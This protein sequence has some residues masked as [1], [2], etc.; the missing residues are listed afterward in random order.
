MLFSNFMSGYQASGL[1]FW[2]FF[3]SSSAPLLPVLSQRVYYNSSY[4]SGP[5]DTPSA[6][7]SIWQGPAF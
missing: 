5:P 2:P 6:L 7:L 3:F 1:P 4:I